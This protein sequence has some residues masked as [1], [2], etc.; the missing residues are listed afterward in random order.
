M[1]SPISHPM[2]YTFFSPQPSVW[3]GFFYKGTYCPFLLF[4][5][6]ES[7]RVVRPLPQLTGEEDAFDSTLISEL[8]RDKLTAKEVRIALRDA[9]Y[10][11]FASC[12]TDLRGFAIAHVREN[13]LYVDILVGSGCGGTLMDYLQSCASQ[14]PVDIKSIVLESIP[15]AIGFYVKKGFI[16]TGLYSKENN[17]Y[18]R[19]N[20]NM[21]NYQRENTW[22]PNNALI[23]DKFRP[24]LLI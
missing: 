17:P 21:N 18:Y 14:H 19:W 9:D 12:G 2:K 1:E 13:S 20:I 3:S 23:Y 15:S 5:H 10:I 7:L 22:N 8:C 4:S 11:F 6:T 24:M 16:P